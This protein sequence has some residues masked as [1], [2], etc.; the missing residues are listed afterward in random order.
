MR[1]VIFLSYYL[2]MCSGTADAQQP[3]SPLP[4]SDEKV[5][6]RAYKQGQDE[7]DKEL[8]DDRATIYTFGL[9][10]LFEHLD[11][12][13]GLPYEGIAG[14]E[15]DDEILGRA[16]GHNDRMLEHI[17]KNG[18]PGYSFKRWEKELFDLK[19]FYEPQS[20]DGKVHRLS[21]GDP[22]MKSPDGGVTIRAV[23][24]TF[25]KDDGSLGDSLAVEITVDGVVKKPQTVFFDEGDSDFCW[26]PKGSNFAVVRSRGKGEPWFMALD[27]R[28]GQRLREG[29]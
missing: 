5:Y 12:D 15:V 6:A 24:R 7:A 14:C 25:T 23:K 22:A 28:T 21:L 29:R 26:G 1:S 3:K 27:L 10:S 19:G 18:P 20:R 2:L 13:T 4:G 9:R 16:A 8:K 11:R 17:K